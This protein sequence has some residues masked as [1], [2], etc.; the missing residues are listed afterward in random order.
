MASFI[1]AIAIFML[2]VVLLW[3]VNYRLLNRSTRKRTV[4]AAVIDVYS[5][6]GYHVEIIPEESDTAHPV[7]LIQLVISYLTTVLYNV[8]STKLYYNEMHQY[9]NELYY[10]CEEHFGVEHEELYRLKLNNL[11]SNPPS[12]LKKSG[13]HS[14]AGKDSDRYHA[15][16]IRNSNSSDGCLTKMPVWG[17][18]MNLLNSCVLLF[19]EVASQLSLDYL[20][21]LNDSCALVANYYREHP[22]EVG[23]NQEVAYFMVTQAIKHDDSDIDIPLSR[24]SDPTLYM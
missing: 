21:I 11:I 16:L 17:Y 15:A 19:G 14:G 9:L 22:V 12:S 4:V 10:L 2:C 1:L 6:G 5:T 18:R 24:R 3:G 23:A 20:R 13:K 8:D 7:D